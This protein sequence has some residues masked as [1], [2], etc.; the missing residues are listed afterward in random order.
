MCGVKRGSGRERCGEKRGM[1]FYIYILTFDFIV[2]FKLVYFYFFI[3]KECICKRK[4]VLIDN[5]PLFKNI[6]NIV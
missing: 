6:V 2:F 3:Q 1:L 4:I 5:I